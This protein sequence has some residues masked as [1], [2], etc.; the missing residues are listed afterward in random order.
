MPSL[1][2]SLGLLPPEARDHEPRVALDGGADG[3]DL[4]RRVVV[5]APRWLAPGGVLLV[6]TSTRQVPALVEAV[7]EAG[8]VPGVASADERSATVVTGSRTA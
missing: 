4:L 1:P 5:A 6:E 8:L 7:V 2:V 3:L